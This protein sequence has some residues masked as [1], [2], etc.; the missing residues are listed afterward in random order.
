[1]QA[2]HAA[3]SANGAHKVVRALDHVLSTFVGDSGDSNCSRRSHAFRVVSYADGFES[4]WISR[5]KKSK[6]LPDFMPA[7]ESALT[8][9][10]VWDGMPK[11]SQSSQVST[12]RYLTPLDW[13]VGL[14]LEI[15]SAITSSNEAPP[16]LRVFIVDLVSSSLSDSDGVRFFQQL[17]RRTLRSLPWLRLVRPSGSLNLD[18]MIGNLIG[19]ITW[20]PTESETA[21]PWYVP[22][23]SQCYSGGSTPDLTL[24]RRIWSANLTQPSKSDDRHAIAN[25]IGPMLLLGKCDESLE[26]R[27][28]WRLL[29][30]VGLLSEWDLQSES[31]VSRGNWIS[32]ND[33]KWKALTRLPKGLNTRPWNFL[34][35]DDGVFQNHWGEFVCRVL[36]AGTPTTSAKS[37]SP[38]CIGQLKQDDLEVC[39]FA[40]ASPEPWLHTL[41][42]FDGTGR[43]NFSGTRFCLPLWKS[44][45]SGCVPLDVLLLDLRLF[46]AR[47]ADAEI[48][49]VA[50]LL[51]VARNAQVDSVG[52]RTLSSGQG[53]LSWPGFT[54]DEL[55]KLEAWTK[56][57]AEGKR[58]DRE[59]H[60]DYELVLTLFPR[61][62]AL[63]DMSLP[64]IL[65]SSTGRRGIS[66]KLKAYGNII[67]DF[68]KPRLPATDPAYVL[69]ESRTKF[70]RALATA[71][72]MAR[73][74]QLLARLVRVGAAARSTAEIGIHTTAGSK[75]PC[76]APTR[77]IEVFL[78]ESGEVEKRDFCV[79]GIAL[80]FDSKDR[81]NELN[82]WLLKERLIWGI[83]E[84]HP[85]RSG[86][87]KEVFAALNG[88]FLQ[89][90]PRDSVE[91]NKAITRI[92]DK[93]IELGGA[94][95]AFGIVRPDPQQLTLPGLTRFL[96]GHLL[97]LINRQTVVNA[98]ESLLFEVL[99]PTERCFEL[100]LH[101]P[102]RKR[103]VLANDKTT[104]E[105]MF[106]ISVNEETSLDANQ[107]NFFYSSIA[108]KDC[109]EIVL[110]VLASRPIPKDCSV[111]VK[112]A[113]S[114]TLYDFVKCQK[115][116]NTGVTGHSRVKNAISRMQQ[117]RPQQIHYLAD[118]IA[119]ILRDGVS[120]YPTVKN[121]LCRGFLEN[122]EVRLCKW[123]QAG[124]AV[125]QDHHVETAIAATSALA[126]GC[127]ERSVSMW[128]LCRVGTSLNQMRGDDFT[129]FCRELDVE[130]RKSTLMIYRIPTSASITD[131]KAVLG[132][133]SVEHVG[134]IQLDQK[135]GQLWTY[136]VFSSPEN[137]KAA[138]DAIRRS[139]AG[140]ST[141]P[142]AFKNIL[143]FHRTTLH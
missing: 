10:V 117:S 125:D 75:V 76:A 29:Q 68:E 82:D 58:E 37:D 21:E 113:R 130:N 15:D 1:M 40:Q 95:T 120:Q 112:R 80:A 50:Q 61:L 13:V 134:N 52:S 7:V 64:I 19:N 32:W 115:L 107:P 26:A 17:P 11:R 67:T 140:Q 2:Q 88:G 110:Q 109:A 105:A 44:S 57:A 98:L 14:S 36:G 142:D 27:A 135:R 53:Q 38:P 94:I 138:L 74:R 70:I 85:P 20:T 126:G 79:G 41:Q 103:T 43:A 77:F 63:A 102:T 62:L 118:W 106:G 124:R 30:Q 137:A 28:L 72:P 108:A 35:L 24:L 3:L 91:Q 71:L 136:A 121:W 47:D 22:F 73:A 139:A 81:S 89:K 69:D 23:L 31:L 141:F 6:S 129:D 66:E 4:L 56:V 25:L 128:T 92:H 18:W 96:E 65:F 59:R 83:A 48:K 54:V 104:F 16:A 78:D 100:D 87:M 97:D 123:L 116:M 132:R 60:P 133:F 84:D 12:E 114:V 101:L 45:T 93:V 42:L 127:D 39:V 119:R 90:Q 33:E 131:L 5:G 49:F 122:D 46:Q 99:L 8:L 51:P 9:V 86:K 55:N 143:A 34:V 111:T